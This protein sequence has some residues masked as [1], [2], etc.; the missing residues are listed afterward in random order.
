LGLSKIYFWDSP[1][2]PNYLSLLYNYR[3]LSVESIYKTYENQPLLKGVSFAVGEHEVVC[4]LGAS[5]SGKSTLLRIIAGLELAESGRILWQG[6]DLSPVPVHKRNFGLMFQDYAL[7][8]HRTV[9]ENVAFGLRMQNLPR[10]DIQARAAEAL[11]QVD[12]Q[13]FANRRVTDL[14]GG[15]QQRVALARAI[16]PRPH[17][18]MLDEP[19][20]A[21]DWALRAQLLDELRRLL[22]STGIPAIYVTH[23]QEEAFTIADRLILLHNGVIEQQGTP[24][25]VYHSPV[26]T[27]AAQF[28]GIGNRIEGTVR[29][30]RPFQVQ[31]S[32]GVFTLDKAPAGQW[33]PG[34]PVL[35]LL[36]PD[37]ARTDCRDPQNLVEGRIEDVIFRGEGSR[38]QIQPQNGPALQFQ[39]SGSFRVG[40]ALRLEIQPDGILCFHAQ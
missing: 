33:L 12:M 27:W 36:R 24:A 1:K 35:L 26:S 20:G 3:M 31:T 6:Q 15:E 2:T 40:V 17:L 34:E 22:H 9:A 23:D 30:T 29:I 13:T 21:L 11:E 8:P 7:F 14:S 16:A 4:L 10:I 5:G 32:L 25:E 18:L 19:L 38:V 28:L 37:A 39:L